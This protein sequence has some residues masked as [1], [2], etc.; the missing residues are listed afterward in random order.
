MQIVV[1]IFLSMVTGG[2]WTLS[3]AQNSDIS[4]LRMKSP[5]ASVLCGK[6]ENK[7][8]LSYKDLEDPDKIKELF[9]KV[10]I[11]CANRGR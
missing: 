7:V 4:L 10:D 2:L 5:E 3:L 9:S 6:E 8:L 11:V 1:A